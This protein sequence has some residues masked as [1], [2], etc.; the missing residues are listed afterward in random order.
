MH[1]FCASPGDV[2]EMSYRKTLP[3]GFVLAMCLSRDSAPENPGSMDA[4][5]SRTYLYYY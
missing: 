5:R 1:Q 4:P 2:P 3:L